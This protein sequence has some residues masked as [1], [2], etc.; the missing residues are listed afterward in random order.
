[1]DSARWNVVTA[2]AS[3]GN[4]ASSVVRRCLEWCR[5]HEQSSGLH[6]GPRASAR[7]I[8]GSG[9]NP[10]RARACRARELLA[11][12]AVCAARTA[13]HDLLLASSPV[14]SRGSRCSKITSRMSMVE[15]ER[16]G[17]SDSPAL[18]RE[19]V[20]G[21]GASALRPRRAVARRLVARPR[22]RRRRAAILRTSGGVALGSPRSCADRA[23]RRDGDRTARLAHVVRCPP[24]LRAGRPRTT[25]RRPAASR[26]GRERIAQRG[27]DAADRLSPRAPPTAAVSRR[28]C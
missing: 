1:M 23:R 4:D 2:A 3:R 18:T 27:V 21:G 7:R 20:A 16:G 24:D 9:L 19:A 28:R 6:T 13:D 10:A 17:Q 11:Q 26:L 5:R 8:G 25:R 12:P 14:R 22:R 15:V